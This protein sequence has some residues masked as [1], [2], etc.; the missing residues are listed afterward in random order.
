M[1]QPGQLLEVQI[2]PV[3]PPLTHSS[4]TQLRRDIFRL[5]TVGPHNPKLSIHPC[6]PLQPSLD[7]IQVGKQCL[8]QS[9]RLAAGF[10]SG[11]PE[12]FRRRGRP[13]RSS[14]AGTL[15]SPSTLLP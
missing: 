6:S 4:S 11:L 2:L 3:S 13:Q 10:S 1:D 15:P 7:S 5:R 8:L 12:S 14:R 9:E